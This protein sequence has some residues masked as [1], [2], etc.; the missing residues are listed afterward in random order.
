MPMVPFLFWPFHPLC[1]LYLLGVYLISPW[2]VSHISLGCASSFN[3]C[4]FM[5]A[6]SFNWCLL[7]NSLFSNQRETSVDF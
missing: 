6:S 3:L 1:I 5:N 7:M 2:G 4:L